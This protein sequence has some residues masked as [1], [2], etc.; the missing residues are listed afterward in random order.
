MAVMIIMKFIKNN[1]KTSPC[2]NVQY[3]YK[4]IVNKKYLLNIFT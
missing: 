1:I 3:D 4:L 2:E